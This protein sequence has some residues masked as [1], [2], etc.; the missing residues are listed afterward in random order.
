MRKSKGC[1]ETQQLIEKVMPMFEHKDFS[2]CYAYATEM[3]YTTK[4]FEIETTKQVLDWL[5]LSK[6]NS[7]KFIH[8]LWNEKPIYNIIKSSEYFSITKED[9][10]EI[11]NEVLI[12]TI[13][14]I[15]VDKLPY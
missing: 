9:I 15:D 1:Q 6:N 12:C 14:D 2:C 13:K 8:C 4:R 5:S 10:A 11:T 7:V 3:G